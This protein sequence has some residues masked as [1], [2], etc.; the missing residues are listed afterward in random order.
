MA[1]RDGR[2]R[3]RFL[4]VSSS[5]PSAKKKE[6]VKVRE[7]QRERERETDTGKQEEEEEAAVVKRKE[8]RRVGF[9]QE[10]FRD[11]QGSRATIRTVTAYGIRF[12]IRFQRRRDD[13][14]PPKSRYA[15]PAVCRLDAIINSE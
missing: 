1:D 15:R 12:G 3:K 11:E 6:V 9:R 10:I 4:R 14:S 7:R 5:E 2:Q 13:V 8:E